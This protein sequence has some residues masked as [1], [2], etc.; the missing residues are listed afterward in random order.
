MEYG[1]GV[2]PQL[3]MR[4]A[5]VAAAHQVLSQAAGMPPD[6]VIALCQR[7]TPTI[8]PAMVLYHALDI[9]KLPGKNGNPRYERIPEL[10]EVLVHARFTVLD[11]GGRAEVGG[12]YEAYLEKERLD[13][14]PPNGLTAPGVAGWFRRWGWLFFGG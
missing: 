13:V 2:N 5:A 9:L 14:Y 11:Y 4:D 7:L 8:H 10:V 1:Y 6:Q 3:A 12:S